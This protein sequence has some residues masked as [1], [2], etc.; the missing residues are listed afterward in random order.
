MSV[1][2]HEKEI[3]YLSQ[4]TDFVGRENELEGERGL[5]LCCL[6]RPQDECYLVSKTQ[7]RG[8]KIK[9]EINGS[10]IT[11]VKWFISRKISEVIA[12]P[13]REWGKF[14]RAITSDEV[15]KRKE[16]G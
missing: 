1:V 10:C 7:T 5:K 11:P 4:L 9:T 14:L 12:I 8:K 2:R 13:Q 6:S 3:D 15:H 16:N